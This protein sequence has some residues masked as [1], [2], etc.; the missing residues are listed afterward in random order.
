[1]I[2]FNHWVMILEKLSNKIHKSRVEP[3]S[4]PPITNV[5]NG[6]FRSMAEVCSDILFGVLRHRCLR[7]PGPHERN[8]EMTRTKI[9]WSIILISVL[10]LMW[11]PPIFSQDA[12]K[13]V[14]DCFNY[15]RGKA[16]EAVVVM[17][18]HRPDWERTM[19]LRAWTQGEKNSLI[20]T[21]D[22]PKDKGNGTLKKDREMWIYNPKVNRVVKLPPSM[23]SQSWMGSDFSNND[24]AKSDTLLV[25]YTHEIIGTETHEGKTVYVIK[26]IPKP[27]APVVWGMQKLK[28]REDLIMLR[29]E[30]YDEDENLVKYITMSNIRRVGDRFFPCVWKMVD[31]EEKDHYTLLN[32]KEVT[33]KQ[34]LPDSIFTI[35]RLKNPIH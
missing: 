17:T 4:I 29:E 30:F 23:M 5:N 11:C 22:P 27:Q 20:L 9:Y 28:I 1:M 12:N 15:M 26:S 8:R 3:M 14:D 35:S 7:Y 31:T 16:S 32:H 21:I 34:S 24:L 25:D 18:I 2:G 6:G 19:T 33:F 13:I 10:T